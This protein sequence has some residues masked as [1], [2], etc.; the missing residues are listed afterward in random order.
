[1]TTTGKVSYGSPVT[2]T[3]TLVSLASDANLLAGRESATLDNSSALAMDYILGGKVTTGT[4]PTTAKQIE[5]WVAGSYDGTTYSGGAT[6]ADAN[7]TFASE[8]TSLKLLTVLPTDATSNHTYEW[9]PF[10]VAQAFGG[11]VPQKWNVFIVHNTGVNLNS[12]GGNHEVKCTPI[13][14]TS[15]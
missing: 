3:M 13:N 14:F 9:G 8:K 10:C 7:L 2:L 11:M 12:T 6:G 1:M 5:V 15:T 4:T